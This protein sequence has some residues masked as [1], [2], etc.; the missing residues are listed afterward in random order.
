MAFKLNEHVR[1]LTED[2]DGIN[3]YARIDQVDTKRGY[4]ITNMNMPYSGTLNKWVSTK[5]IAHQPKAVVW[6]DV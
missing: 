5:E 3:G 4:F 2:I 1:V 6:S